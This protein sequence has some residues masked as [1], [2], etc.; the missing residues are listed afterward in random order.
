[1]G[2]PP[3]E[4]DG[5]GIVRPANRVARPRTRRPRRRRRAA[6]R[7]AARGTGEPGGPEQVADGGGDRDVVARQPLRIVARDQGPWVTHNE[8][9]STAPGLGPPA[10]GAA[11]SP[12]A[13]G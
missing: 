13:R 9:S 6:R 3:P 7:G 10:P 1:M 5:E 11:S 2:R 4:R 12:P 8:R